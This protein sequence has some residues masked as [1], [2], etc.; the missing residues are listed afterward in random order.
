[1][2]CNGKGNGTLIPP[3]VNILEKDNFPFFVIA[4]Q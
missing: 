4:H 1:M 3:F 2:E